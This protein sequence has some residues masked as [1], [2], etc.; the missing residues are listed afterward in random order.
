MQRI[1][2]TIG[3]CPGMF[4][5]LSCRAPCCHHGCLLVGDDVRTAEEHVVLCGCHEIVCGPPPFPFAQG[6]P[7]IWHRDLQ[8][9]LGQ[10][11]LFAGAN[12]RE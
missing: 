6:G 8:D 12:Q 1:S 11:G 2:K 10:I 5:V 3:T 4:L 9:Q 7:R